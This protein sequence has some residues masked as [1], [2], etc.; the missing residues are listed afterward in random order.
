[1]VLDFM[2]VSFEERRSI[3]GFCRFYRCVFSKEHLWI[4]SE[5]EI[6]CCDGG[7]ES[8][9]IGTEISWRRL[10]EKTWVYFEH[11]HYFWYIIIEFWRK[12]VKFDLSCKLTFSNVC[13]KD[14]LN[15]PLKV[16]WH[17]VLLLSRRSLTVLIYYKIVADT[18]RRLYCISL[19]IRYILIFTV[20]LL[21]MIWIRDNDHLFD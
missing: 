3:F 20:M 8:L 15:V 11:I 21:A 10:K 12:P 19:K 14:M 7:M 2:S 9:F 18:L 1:M 5:A 16:R 4:W 17:T 6:R 13:V